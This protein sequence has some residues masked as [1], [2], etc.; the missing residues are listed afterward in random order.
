MGRKGVVVKSRTANGK[1]KNNVVGLEAIN[2]IIEMLWLL[3]YLYVCG[4]TLSL[5]G[6]GWGSLVSGRVFVSLFWG[7][8]AVK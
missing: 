3:N 8:V 2:V 5:L 7:G 6:M 1:L 4:S